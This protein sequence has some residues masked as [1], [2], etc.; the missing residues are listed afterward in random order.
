MFIRVS[1]IRLT[2]VA[3]FP[4]WPWAPCTGERWLS[5]RTQHALLRPTAVTWPPARTMTDDWNPVLGTKINL[6]ALKLPL[7]YFCHSNRK[8]SITLSASNSLYMY[9]CIFTPFW[10]RVLLYR[11]GCPRTRS[12]DQAGLCLPCPRS[13]SMCHHTLQYVIFKKACQF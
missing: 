11:P 10:D 5:A 3:T 1:W 2:K 8:G 13:K 6:L 9:K 4:G 12:A 7:G